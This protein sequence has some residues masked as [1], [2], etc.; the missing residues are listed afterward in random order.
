M[1]WGQQLAF[2]GAEGFGRNTTG[3]RG[4]DVYVVTNLT[5]SVT[6]PEEGS[7]RWALNKS[8]PR[9]IV[10]AISGTIELKRRLSVSK[11]DVTIAGQSAPGD[12]ICIKGQTVS[13][14]ADNVIIRYIR[15]RCG[16]DSPTEEPPDAITGIRHRNIIIDHCSMSWSVDETASFYDNTDFTMQWCIISESL[17]SAGHYKGE[18]GYGGI[19]GGMGASFH[20]N[21]LAD[22]TSRNPRFCGARYHPE[23]KETEIVDFRNNVIFN[24]GFNSSY[25]GELG[26]QNMV[27]NYYKPGPATKKSVRE[28][29]VEPFD[30]L[31]RWFIKGNYMSGSRMVTSDNWT[32]GVQGDFAQASGI[33]SNEPFPFAPVK[34]H[35]ATTAYRL[36]MKDAG[37]VLPRRDALDERIISETITGICAYG[38]SYGAGTGIIDSQNNTERWP[39][40]KT[41]N[42]QPDSDADGM[43]DNWEISEG[44]N[45]QDSEDRNIV[46]KSGY[47]MLEEYL[48]TA[49]GRH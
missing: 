27:N 43:P 4:G 49:A 36:V 31:G 34:T 38:D 17:F 39:E 26:K 30:S 47:T 20:H 12:G 11:G 19:W 33:R 46:A 25:G 24:W 3:G 29:I 18:H 23:T 6:K 7:L 14:D 21:L 10:F 2:P 48:N 13:V 16:I 41:Y 9:T 32:G 28:R 45:P 35:R 22:H 5:D 1:A 40:L 15:F 8:G 42:L 44:L 37:A